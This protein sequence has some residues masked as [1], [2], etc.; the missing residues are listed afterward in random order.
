MV[1]QNDMTQNVNRTQEKVKVFSLNEYILH[2]ATMLP[3]SPDSR[4]PRNEVTMELS[5]AAFPKAPIRQADLRGLIDGLR[6]GRC[7]SLVGPSNTGKSTLLKSLPLDEVRRLC[8]RANGQ[9]PIMVFIDCLEAGGSEQAFYE[10]LLRRMIEELHASDTSAP[11]LEA[12]TALHGDILRSANEVA[13]RSS[14]A[15]AVRRLEQ[16][17]DLSLVLILDEFDDVF[18]TLPPWPFRQLRALYDDLAARLGYVTGTFYHLE[19][20]RPDK[21]T[22]EFRELFHLHTLVLQPLPAAEARTFVAYLAEK[23]GTRLAPANAERLIELSGGHPGLLER[24]YTVLQTTEPDLTMPL[25]LDLVELGQRRPIQK[26]S[27]RLW[28]ELTE[29]EQQGLL[30][31]VERGGPSLSGS[32]R[33]VLAAKGLV[34]AGQGPEPL[35]FSPIFAAFVRQQ[36]VQSAGPANRG[37]RCDFETGQIWLDER[38][39][40][41]RLS[42]PQRQLVMFLYRQAGAVSSYDQIAAE[43]WGTGEGVSPGAIYELVK[44]LRQKIEPDWRNPRHIVTVPGKGYRLETGR[45]E[46]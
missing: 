20:L 14:Y 9:A 1:A 7:C 31:L 13:I 15:S 21:E 45:A 17:P 26:E 44:R 23:Q 46:N 37:L 5:R 39:L 28:S 6:R 36:S 8:A 19:Q 33:Q 25:D 18:R 30:S 2:H 41:L 22:Y 43:V 34:A 42:E 16:Q 40:T 3:C 35:V 27:L 24:L 38:E 10:L 32:Q 4:L 12:L 11:M 29:E